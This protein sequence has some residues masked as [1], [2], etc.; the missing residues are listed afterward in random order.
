PKRLVLAIAAVLSLIVPLATG[1]IDAAALAAGQLPGVAPSG[2]PV[3]PE[4]RFEVVSIKAFD[5][6]GPM[7]I[8][9]TPGRYDNAGMP[10][11]LAIGQALVVPL[12]R[13]IGLPD[14]TNTERF[15]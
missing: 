7:R 14:W 4:T 5:T 8:S 10:L 12:N 3:D 6:S 2:P 9:M 15:T 13:I 1:A 11:G